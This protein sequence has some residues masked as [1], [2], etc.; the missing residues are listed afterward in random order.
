[1]A[2]RGELEVGGPLLCTLLHVPHHALSR[3]EVKQSPID[4]QGKLLASLHGVE[5][6]GTGHL[7]K[8][9]KIAMVSPPSCLD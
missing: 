1:M 5:A 8:C 6:S 9:I 4:D 7:F 2:V 3:V